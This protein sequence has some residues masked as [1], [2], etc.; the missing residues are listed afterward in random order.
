VLPILYLAA[1]RIV[2]HPLFPETHAIVDDPYTHAVYAAA[3][4][5]GVAAAG[6]EGIWKGVVARWKAAALL[7]AAAYAAIVVMDVV[8]AGES[9]EI[10]LLARRIAR[11]IQAW[12][13][14]VALLGFALMHLHRDGSVRRYLTDA[15]FP[16]Y[17]AHQ[18]IIVVAGHALKPQGLAP[19]A[20]FAIILA[21]TVVG[22]FAFYEGGRRV[23][24]LRPLIGLAPGRRAS[25]SPV[26][27]EGA[28]SAPRAG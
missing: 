23:S 17:I 28:A 8:I 3:F 16:W 12:G 18:T 15:I 14:T 10:E 21:A 5:F 1:T 26:A 22:C 9:G 2:L 25:G 20:E 27:E 11:S 6:S 13:V 19:S 7:G 4:F 24:W